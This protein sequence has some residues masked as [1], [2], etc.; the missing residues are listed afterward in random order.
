MEHPRMNKNFDKRQSLIW[1]LHKDFS[2]K[3]FVIFWTIW[4]KFNVSTDNFSTYF[5]LVSSERCSSM[6]KFVE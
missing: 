2:D 4:S 1:V 5:E 6:Y 3:I